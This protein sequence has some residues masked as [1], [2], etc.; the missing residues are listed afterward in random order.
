MGT[1]ECVLL[2]SLSKSLSMAHSAH[3]PYRVSVDLTSG[4]DAALFADLC[5]IDPSIP[6][7]LDAVIGEVHRYDS[8]LLELWREAGLLGKVAT[9][10]LHYLVPFHALLY[11]GHPTE[12]ALLA[13]QLMSC[14]AWRSYDNCVDGHEA[15]R[16]AH[17]HSLAACIRLIRYVE[18]T[19]DTQAVDGVKDIE[20]HY[21]LMAIQVERELQHPVPVGEIWKRCS[22]FLYAPEALAGL[23]DMRVRVFRD[24]I[25]Y[26]G[27]A[28]DLSDIMSDIASG[29]VSLPLRWLSEVA[30]SGIINVAVMEQVYERARH[31]VRPIEDGFAAAGVQENYPLIH[32]LLREASAVFDGR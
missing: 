28:H 16:I 13:V 18:S 10:S 27:L 24:Y 3:L 21:Q 20:M 6:G 17:L 22:L 4:T 30:D 32:R 2:S 25:N 1:P 26:T 9:Y 14:L 7:I 5:D 12:T 31:A 19:F 29:V 15:P 8:S 23:D 11:R